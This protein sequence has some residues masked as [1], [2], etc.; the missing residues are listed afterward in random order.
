[1]LKLNRIL[2][3]HNKHEQGSPEVKERLSRLEQ[4]GI[5]YNIIPSSGISTIWREYDD[6]HAAISHG[7]IRIKTDLDLTISTISPE[8]PLPS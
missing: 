2:Y 6:G 1:M 4:H 7:S 8:S 3:F 5:P